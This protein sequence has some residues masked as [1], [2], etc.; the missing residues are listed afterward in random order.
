M[1]A[2]PVSSGVRAVLDAPRG[3]RFSKPSYPPP[4]TREQRLLAQ[5]E[6]NPRVAYRQAHGVLPEWMHV[7]AAR[8]DERASRTT[9]GPERPRKPI[10]QPARP[11][12]PVVP[13]PRPAPDDGPFPPRRERP[14][15]P[16][17]RP[18]RPH[19]RRRKPSRLGHLSHLG[20]TART[21]PARLLAAYTLASSFG[22][23]AHHLG[24]VLL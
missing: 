13:R 6:G 16:R 4:L 10:T 18:K 24:T 14:P 2:E 3:R 19:G 9:E 23:L 11:P 21:G 8:L 12:E 7:H 5:M 15:L 1:T 20:G 22:A 17:R